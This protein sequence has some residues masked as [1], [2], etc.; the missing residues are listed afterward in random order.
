MRV[1][2]LSTYKRSPQYSVLYDVKIEMS[3]L[4]Y[5]TYLYYIILCNASILVIIICP[6]RKVINFFLLLLNKIILIIYSI[7]LVFL[8]GAEFLEKYWLLRVPY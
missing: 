1:L 6:A 5:V 8:N 3:I 4:V 7:I 2:Y